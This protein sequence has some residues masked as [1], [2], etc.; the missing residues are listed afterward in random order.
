MKIFSL[1][2]ILTFVI[3]SLVQH[4][5]L[6]TIKEFFESMIVILP[7]LLLLVFICWQFI[8]FV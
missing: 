1:G 2:F 5:N 7:S 6:T 4:I 8:D 3:S